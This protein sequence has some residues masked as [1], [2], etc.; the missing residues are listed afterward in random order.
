MYSPF[1]PH[2]LT[3][4]ERY[5][6]VSIADNQCQNAGYASSRQNDTVSY[7]DTF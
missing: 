3:I 4:Y 5:I 2:Y 7:C 1:H 6:N